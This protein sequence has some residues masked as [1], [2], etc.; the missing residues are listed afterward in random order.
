MYVC[1]GDSSLGS[2]QPLQGIGALCH[3]YGCLLIV[4]AVVSLC[5]TPLAMDALEIDVLFSGAQKAMSGPPGVAL[6]SFS[7]R[8]VEVIRKRSVNHPISSYYNDILLVAKSWGIDNNGAYKYHYTHAI[9]L[10]FGLHR[11]LSLI[12]EE[13]LENVVNKHSQAKAYFESLLPL[14]QPDC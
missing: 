2:L 9:N 11:T 12:V 4:D 6:I 3:R 7:D 10:F 13:G 8:A 5:T 1:H 14:V